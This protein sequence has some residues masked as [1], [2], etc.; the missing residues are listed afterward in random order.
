MAQAHAH[1]APSICTLGGICSILVGISYVV[2]GIATLLDPTR[3]SSTFWQTLVEAPTWFLISRWALTVGA[4]LALAVVPAVAHLLAPANVGWVTWHSKLADVGFFV[5]ALASVQAVSVEVLY[6]N[7]DPHSWLTIGCVGL[8][9]LGINVLALQSAAWPKPLAY[10]G[11]VVACMYGCALA[12]NALAMPQLFAIA[13][14][15]GGIVLG[16]IWYV[17]I[18]QRLRRVDAVLGRLEATDAG[19]K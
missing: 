7:I 5:T 18:G 14:G 6:A 2:F 15:L 19:V 4:L 11:L 17:W 8:W 13:A 1:Q 9:M 10:L 12:G 3:D 16:P